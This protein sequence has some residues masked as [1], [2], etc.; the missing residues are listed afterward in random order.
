MGENTKIEWADHTASFW[1]GCTKVAP[2]CKNCYAETYAK[3]V[4]ND[5][6]GPKKPRKWTKGGP[7]L[8]RKLNRKAKAAGR[9]DTVFVNDLADFFEDHDGAVV[10]HKGDRVR[11][12]A[13]EHPPASRAYIK[14]D[15]WFPE[16]CEGTGAFVTVEDLRG[17]AFQLFDE[18]QNL[19]FMLLTK[20]PENIRRMW[21]D[22]DQDDGEHY[23]CEEPHHDRTTGEF[24]DG[25]HRCRP[26]YRNNVML[27]TSVATQEDANKNISELLKCRDL[28]PCLFVSAEPLL[29]SV[30]LTA[31]KRDDGW[32]VDA[33]RGIYSREHFETIDTQG[34]IEEHGDGPHVDWV[35]I[36]GESGGGSRRCDVESVI[37]LANQCQRASV[38]AFIKQLGFRVFDARLT[39]ATHYEEQHCWPDGTRTDHHAVLLNH[40][41]GGDPAEWPKSLRIRELPEFLNE[42]T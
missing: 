18:C 33:L 3:R 6:W 42:R 29:E 35:I 8:I 22:R 11:W 32:T 17:E 28:S 31:V 4:G 36:G 38:P 25:V 2:G 34:G 37:F 13:N 20:R 19:I 16:D 41:K 12:Y 40:L 21:I 7:G 5:V 10:D 15:G 26:E 14:P 1:E 39:S 30:D 9:I 27:G 23:Y 24:V